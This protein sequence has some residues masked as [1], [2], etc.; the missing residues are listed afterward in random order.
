MSEAAQSESAQSGSIESE[1]A[2]EA[3]YPRIINAERGAIEVR[4][5]R[6]G[7]MDDLYHQLLKASWPRFFGL[8]ALA[9]LLLNGVFAFA[10]WVDRGGV[11][12]LAEGSWLDAFFFSVQTFGTIGYGVM[13]PRDIYSNLLVTAESFVGLFS[14]AAATGLIFARISRPTARVM[15]SSRAVITDFDGRRM[16]IFR[17]ANERANQIL[18]AEITVSVARQMVTHEGYT[19]R[20]MHDLNVVRSRSPLFALTWM[21]MHPIDET[22]PLFGAT[23]DSLT[24]DKVEVLVVLAGIDETFAQRI[25]ARHSYMPS[26]IIWDRQFADILFIGD[27]GQ[28]VIDYHRFH[29]FEDEMP[30]QGPN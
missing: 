18:E 23:R 25:H 6:D 28:R 29:L 7:G 10:Y 24:K 3:P 20:R 5:R 9:F 27:N 30:Q 11:Q 21:V 22:S 13:A 26:E 2:E 14:V 8:S 16:L 17:C 19:V 12:G 4:G 1:P 15:F